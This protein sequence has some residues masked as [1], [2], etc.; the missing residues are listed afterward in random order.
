MRSK[1]HLVLVVILF[2]TPLKMEY[3]V[4]PGIKEEKKCYCCEGVLSLDS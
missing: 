2:K 4:C 3:A 1:C